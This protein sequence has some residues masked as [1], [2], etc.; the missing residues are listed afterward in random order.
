MDLLQERD[1]TRAL[2]KA[3]I[4]S[5]K[6]TINEKAKTEADYRILLREETLKLRAEGMAVGTIELTVYG[7]P[8]V[9]EARMKRDIADETLKANYEAIQVY[10]L[11]LRIIE[12]EISREYG[13][14]GVQI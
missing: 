2:L 11:D 10:K 5:L 3:S 9:A 14:S 1:N 6:T 4:R 13:M 7:L 8:N 12:N